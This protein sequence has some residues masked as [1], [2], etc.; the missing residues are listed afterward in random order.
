MTEMRGKIRVSLQVG[1]SI[2]VE[3]GAFQ[4]SW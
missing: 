3:L 2:K 4:D 1:R